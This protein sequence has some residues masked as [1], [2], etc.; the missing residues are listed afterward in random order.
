MPQQKRTTFEQFIDKAFWTLLL[1]VVAFGV[2]FL[3]ELSSSVR[4]LNS[5]MEVV[6][7][8]SQRHSDEISSLGQRLSNVELRL[9]KEL[10]DENSP[11]VYAAPRDGVQR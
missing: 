11:R 3:G 8:Q 2:K 6:V 5:K 1:G 7:Y 9:A 4:D 10:P